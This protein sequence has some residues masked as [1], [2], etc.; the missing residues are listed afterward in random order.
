MKRMTNKIVQLMLVVM[1]LSFFFTTAYGASLGKMPEFKLPS[2]LDGKKVSS[3]DFK[4]Q[5]LLITFFATW[6]PPCRQEI[7]TLVELQSEYGPKG[8]SVIGLSVD[9]KGPKVVV[10]MIKK[11]KINYPVLMA[12]GKTARAFGGVV[13]IPTSFLVDRKGMIVKRYPG[14]VPKALLEKDIKG[15]L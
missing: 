7:P 5:V 8:F 14:Y 6:C 12:R 10:K 3:K 9:E 11:D 13:G 1:T 2:A 4:D 15:I